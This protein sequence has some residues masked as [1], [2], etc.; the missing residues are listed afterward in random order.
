MFGSATTF[1]IKIMLPLIGTFDSKETVI[2]IEES[3]HLFLLLFPRQIV[4]KEMR[5]SYAFQSISVS[6]KMPF[7]LPT[8]FLLSGN[9]KR[10][11]VMDDLSFP[12]LN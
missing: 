3:R 2:S 9:N 4:D 8:C 6:G 1:R 5:C 10:N 12:L 7:Y 11:T